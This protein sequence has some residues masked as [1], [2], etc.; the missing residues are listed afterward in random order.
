MDINKEKR[1]VMKE[2]F[3]LKDALYNPEKI[4]MI[5]Q[6]IKE[7]YPS[8]EALKFTQAVLDPFPKLELKERMYHIRDMIH[9][10]LP[11]DYKKAV[12]IL[13]QS[14]PAPLDTKKN[15]DDFGDFI[16]APYAEYVTAYG[17]NDEHLHFSLEALREITKRFSVEFAIRDFI[18]IYP[19]E[20]FAMLIVCAK[21]ENYHER[22]LA[23]EGLRP[24]LPWAK[25]LTI[26]HDI[27]L[28]HLELLYS[29][30]TRYVTRSVANHLNDLTKM[31]ASLVLEILKRW[32]KSG[33]QESKEMAFIMNHA[34]RTLVKQ[35]NEEALAML[36]YV[37]EP[38]IK[39][40]EVLLK[41]STV[42]VGES[43]EF[44]V[45]IVAKDDVMLMVDY[46]LHFC[47]KKGTLSPKVHKLK[48]FSMKNGENI[49]LQK[50][51]PFRAN[52]STRT[53]YAGSH[54]LEVQVNGT[55]V[56]SEKFILE[57][58]AT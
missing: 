51:H 15:D 8:F 16:Y 11:K 41:T 1:P 49:V 35:G 47:T 29:D 4:S 6:E 32:E 53:L 27:P 5:S 33:K 31:D 34:L 43:L 14:L 54:L 21:S 44:D 18:N 9:K 30:T 19:S 56:Y 36:G 28:K 10:Y 26:A 45:E 23:S 42:Q 37:K 55:I 40:K 38:A 22:R 12:T 50:K 52:M 13:L 17:C 46:V 58:V 7:V 20:T 2:K 3:S 48:K 57:T 39:I 24:K 25:K